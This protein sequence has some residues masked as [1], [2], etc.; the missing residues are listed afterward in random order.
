[1][2]SV[3][4]LSCVRGDRSLFAG[5]DFAVDAGEWLHVRGANGC[6]KT[7][8]LRLLAG[9]SQPAHGAINWCGKPRINPTVSEI[10]ASDLPLRPLARR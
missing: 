6:G 9:L 8:L 3:N 2:L 7:S 5:I 1:M 10:T 4:N